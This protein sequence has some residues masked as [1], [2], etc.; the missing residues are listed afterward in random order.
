M[1]GL[2]MSKLTGTSYLILGMLTSREW[3]A[4]ELAEQVSRGVMEIWPR[5]SRQ[6][7]NAPKQLIKQGL[8]V[9][10]MEATGRRRRSVYSITPEG[11][12]ALREWLAGDTAPTSLESEAMVRVLLADQG[13]I[14][15]LKRTLRGVH[16]SAVAQRRRFEAHAE[17]IA[18]SGGGTFPERRHLFELSTAFLLGHYTHMAQ[19]AQW[20]LREVDDWDDTALPAKSKGSAGPNS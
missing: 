9:A 10:R 20:A 19:W 17:F 14:E 11:R 12:A 6:L 15:D 3:S 7:Y 4:Y 13:T 16:D 2:S 18:T 8:V 5:A 1:G